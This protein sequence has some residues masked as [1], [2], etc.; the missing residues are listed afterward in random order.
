MSKLTITIPEEAHPV[1]KEW[2]EKDQR[3]LT[4]YLTVLLDNVTCTKSL[5]LYLPIEITT[6]IKIVETTYPNGS[7]E[8]QEIPMQVIRRTDKEKTGG[9]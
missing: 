2:A 7:K 1:L 8:K 6:G 4:N 3:S 9:N 5:P